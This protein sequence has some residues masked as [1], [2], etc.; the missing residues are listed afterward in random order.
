MSAGVNNSP[1]LT[2]REM[3]T[4]VSMVDGESIAL[5]GLTSSKQS[6]GSSG[7]PFLPQWSRSKAKNEER[8]ALLIFLRVVK[9]GAGI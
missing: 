8:T 5:G 3:Q 9:K 1:T 2:N 4:S 6:N 7:L